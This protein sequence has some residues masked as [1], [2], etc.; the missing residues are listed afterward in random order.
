[1]GK[2][3]ICKKESNLI[4]SF[5]GL[6]LNCIRNNPEK[7]LP[8][9]EAAHERSRKKFALSWGKPPK[10][11]KTSIQC[12]FCGNEC[13]IP[14]GERGFCGLVKNDGGRILREKEIAASFYRDPHPTNCVSQ[15]ACAASGYGYP[16]FSYCDGIEYGYHN[17][18]V[19]CT[20]CSLDCLFCQNWH[21][22]K[23]VLDPPYISDDKILNSIEEKTSCISFFGGDPSPQLD[24]IIR[25]CRKIKEKF[26]GKILR[27][28]LETNGNA[29]SNIL[30]SFAEI[31]FESGGTQKFDLKFWDENLSKAITGVSNKTTLK[32]F[33]ILGEYVKDRKP[34]F[35]SA[36]TLMVPGY[37]D[38]EE[39]KNITK[40][41]ASIDENIPYSLL[42]FFPNF[43]M[44]DLPLTTR[45]DALNYMKI[46]KA[47]GLK[48]VRIGNVHIL[49]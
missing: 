49:V 20:A 46:A 7:A 8:I 13:T 39:I 31:G 3:Q 16:K 11:E 19:F 43:E 40:F 32:N 4:S 21:F 1:M 12:K 44:S 10:E 42:A 33:E 2:C 36:S 38:E 34:P 6:C 28:C 9:A 26:R 27:F 14:E 45:K 22:R 37:I 25:I 48:N 18:A 5:L 30:K 47:S 29:N 17:L 15:W 41:I 23:E 35:L 24:K